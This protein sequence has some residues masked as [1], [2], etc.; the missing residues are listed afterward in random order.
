M[1]VGVDRIDYTKGIIEKFLAVER[2]FTK[3]PEY[4][5]NFTFVELAAPSRTLIKSYADLVSSVEKEAE[6][7][8]WK[9]R[10]RTW[11][12]ILLLKKHHSHEEIKPFY[13]VAQLC[14]ITSL[15]DGM[16][17]VAKEFIAERNREDG[18]LILSQFAG[19]SQHMPG[20][21]ITNPYDIDGTAD[22][23]F[24]ALAMPENEQKERM[25]LLRQEIV[26]NNVFSWA[27]NLL[28][29]MANLN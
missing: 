15:H 8:N 10:T 20:A 26:T 16:N 23:I 17:L 1:G 21:I 7:I 14:L 29:T 18:V 4:I 12:P 22:A 3:Y 24:Q 27:A 9:F 19:A 25:K 6:R 28:K 2:F 11:K 5:G 13:A